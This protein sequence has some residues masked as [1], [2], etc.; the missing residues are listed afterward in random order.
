MQPTTVTPHEVQA[1]AV[2]PHHIT[3][4]FWS[5]PVARMFLMDLG[6]KRPRC[7]P[8]DKPK[9]A[10]SADAW[11]THSSQT[12]HGTHDV[13]DTT[14]LTCY[15]FFLFVGS[16]SISISSGGGPGGISDLE[17]LKQLIAACGG[18]SMSTPSSS[19]LWLCLSASSS[20]NSFNCSSSS[21]LHLL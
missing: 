3:P 14:T 19:L 12:P 21:H 1:A 13:H 11:R 8:Q 4:H 16:L 6:K 7:P 10:T 5:G 17:L 2:E 15:R 20:F 18:G 9:K